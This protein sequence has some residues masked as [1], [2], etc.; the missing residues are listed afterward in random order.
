MTAGMR[1]VI[2]ATGRL[3]EARLG[4][5]LG[6]RARPASGAMPG[7]K[8][9]HELGDVLIEAKS[10]TGD[11]IP[12]DRR[13]LAKIA[14]EARFEGKVPALVLSFTHGDGRP[15][16]D[17]EWVCIPLWLWRERVQED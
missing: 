9:D 8:G 2:G 12:L 11:R 14:R 16:A 15:I 3:S 17:G 6:A 1:R 5:K 7:A 10:S 4:K 13:W